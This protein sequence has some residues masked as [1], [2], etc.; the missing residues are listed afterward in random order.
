M[1]S[2]ISASS[3]TTAINQTMRPVE[4]ALLL[5]LSVLWGGS[6]FFVEIAVR[7]LPTLT[8][9]T[10]R[11]GL[12]AI[13]LWVVVWRLGLATPRGWALWGAFL[14]MGLLNN[15]IP[16]GLIVWG[17]QTIGSG[18]A[19]ILN[20]TTPLFTIV[21][22]GFLLT[23]EKFTASKFAGVV[24]GFGGV[25]I[26]I[27]PDFV[28]GVGSQV[29]AQFAVLGAALS[30]A[31]AGV[32]GRRFK[33]MGVDPIVAAAGQVTASALV[34]APV[35]L[36]VDRPWTLAPPSATVWAA[37][38]GVAILSTAVAYSLYFRILAHAGATN[39]LLVTFLIPVTAILLGVL[40]L[41]ETLK[42]EHVFGM[43]LIG[44]GLV[45]IDGRVLACLLRRVRGARD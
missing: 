7:E 3:K 41:D 34:L 14:G 20:A 30:Y 26:M 15:V 38:V 12:A 33:T 1:P 28:L 39:L 37:I 32:Y 9:V 8:I 4:W 21:V 36:M 43:A 10:L 23:D 16:F 24:A 25:I 29:S 22:A 6:F 40:V 18:L 19:S 13:A 27:G 31:F 11:V 2:N 5:A 42:T 17:Q 35:A 44:L 45:A